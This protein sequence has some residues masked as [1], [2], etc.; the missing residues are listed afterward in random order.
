MCGERWGE[1]VMVVVRGV[2][3]KLEV[4]DPLVATRKPPNPFRGDSL[5]W[6]VRRWWWGYE[7][8]D[9]ERLWEMMRDDERRLEKVVEG[10]E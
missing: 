4:D 6:S 9:D 5:S 2:N 3:E 8:G 10:G 7:R 1:G